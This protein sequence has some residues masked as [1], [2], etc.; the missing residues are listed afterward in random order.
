MS[1]AV[2]PFGTAAPGSSAARIRPQERADMVAL[3]VV[4]AV[5]LIVLAASVRILKQY[6]RG[7]QFRLGHC[8]LA[9]GA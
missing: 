3:F 4:L 7:V 6:E 8:D 5:A 2:N 1:A 9:A